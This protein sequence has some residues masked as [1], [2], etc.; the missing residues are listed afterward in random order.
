MAGGIYTKM[1]NKM[2][3][4]GTLSVATN[5]L[6]KSLNSSGVSTCHKKSRLSKRQ[7]KRRKAAKMAKQSKKRNRGK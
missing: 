1:M 3:W 7:L 5:N 2:S 6:I 4:L